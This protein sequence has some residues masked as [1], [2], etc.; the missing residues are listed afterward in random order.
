MNHQP[1]SPATKT[2]KAHVCSATN[3]TAFLRKLVSTTFPTITGNAST[4][5]PASLLSA[6]AS[7]SNYFF[8]IPSSFGGEPPFPLPPPKA[9]VMARTIVEIVIEKAV[10]IENIVL[11]CSRNKVRILSANDVF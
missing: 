4:A 7:L 10:S 6:S 11:P 8:K 5:F 1:T 3:P 2:I 9:P